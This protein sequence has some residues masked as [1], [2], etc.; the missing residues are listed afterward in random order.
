MRGVRILLVPACFVVCC[1]KT[2]S[3]TPPTRTGYIDLGR[4]KYLAFFDHKGIKG[5]LLK[6]LHWAFGSVGFGTKNRTVK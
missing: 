5:K 3:G 4:G 1:G 6:K 2:E